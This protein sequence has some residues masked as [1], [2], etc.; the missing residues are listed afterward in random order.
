MADMPTK[1]T[2]I[3][4]KTVTQL[5]KAIDVENIPKQHKGNFNRNYETVLN[6]FRTAETKAIEIDCSAMGEDL[7][8]ESVAHSYRMKCKEL[9]LSYIVQLHKDRNV[10]YLIKK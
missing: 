3:E 4:Q 7:K 6:A 9:K 10:V 1:K 2:V 5:F 8:A